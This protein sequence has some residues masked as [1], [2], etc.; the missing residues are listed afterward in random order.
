MKRIVLLVFL[1]TSFGFSQTQ[2][3]IDSIH[4]VLAQLPNNAQ[5]SVA[6][7][8]GEKVSYYGVK[9]EDGS[10]RTIQ[11]KN[12]VYEIGSIT[13]VMTSTILAS[14]V[15]EGK[16][17]LKKPL[18]DYVPYPL[19]HGQK[20]GNTI[21]IEMLS[22]HSS[23]LTRMPSGMIFDLLFRYNNPYVK[24]DLGRME[25]YFKKKMKL[26]RNPGEK[27][28]YSNI[29]VA[30][31]GHVLEYVANKPYDE[32]LDH[33]VISKYNL[34]ET[35]LDRKIIVDQLVKGIDGDGKVVSN[36]D[37]NAFAPAGA[38]LSS[39]KDMSKFAQ[40]NFTND[41]I[42]KLQRKKTFQY[43]EDIDIALGWLIFNKDGEK[44]YWHNGGTGGYTSAMALNID[45]KTGVVILSN[46]SA[47][48]EETRK[49]DGL[50]FNLIKLID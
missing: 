23:G 13:K 30:Y 39:V 46:V 26:N 40:A 9:K 7:I 35:S 18:Q 36:W 21:T 24:Y 29:G 22:N 28:E 50:S 32:L 43:K 41:P 1:L 25:K 5:L 19:K 16:I 31:L 20:N 45:K 48:V 10:I 37:L 33:Y 3:Q 4:Q 12:N 34:S 17:E 6:I 42:L 2:T 27:S 44:I 49:L 15:H 8:D 14:L 38:L 47:F 11:N